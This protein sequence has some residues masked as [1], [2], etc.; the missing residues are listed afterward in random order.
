MKKEN[1]QITLIQYRD[2]TGFISEIVKYF[3]CNKNFEDT[4][5]K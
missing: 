4:G 2:P 1:K 5:K 3:L